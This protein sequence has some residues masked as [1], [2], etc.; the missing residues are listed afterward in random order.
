M[1][2][3]SLAATALALSLAA[4]GDS[5]DSGGNGGGGSAPAPAA[6]MTPADCK[7]PGSAVG[8]L[9]QRQKKLMDD[10]KANKTGIATTFNSFLATVQAEADKAKA[11]GDWVG[12]CK[13]IDAALTA[14]GY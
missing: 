10:V 7:D 11:S 6:A 1:R 12:Y 2:L 14:A 4:C 5:A 9:D 3:F 13:A 8:Y